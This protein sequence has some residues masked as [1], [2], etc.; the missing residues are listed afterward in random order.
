MTLFPSRAGSYRGHA[1][2]RCGNVCRP[3]LTTAVTG[4]FCRAALALKPY[5]VNTFSRLRKFTVFSDDSSD[6]LELNS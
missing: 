1:R 2:W 6:T 4:D 3:Q 5:P